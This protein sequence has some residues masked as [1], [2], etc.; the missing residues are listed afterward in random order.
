M[1]E[2]RMQEQI[3]QLKAD[4]AEV[5]QYL[6]AIHN[7]LGAERARATSES[8]VRAVDARIASNYYRNR[9]GQK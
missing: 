6:A 5:L 8:H 1:E 9:R 4:F 3:D 7:H 2:K